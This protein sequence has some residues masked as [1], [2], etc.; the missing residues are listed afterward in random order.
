[1]V[2]KTAQ[3]IRS[4]CIDE[5]DDDVSNDGFRRVGCGSHTAALEPGDEDGEQRGEST[6]VHARTVTH[7]REIWYVSLGIITG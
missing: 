3:V 2:A 5:D 1:M 7:A 4:Q 6:I